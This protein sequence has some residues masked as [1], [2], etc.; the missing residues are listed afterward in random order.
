MS[1][2]V[3]VTRLFLRL[4][5]TKGRMIAMGALAVGM[6]LLALLTGNR[7]SPIEQT[8]S[9]FQLYALGG[10]VPIAA[11]VFGS[12]A[13]GDLVE[14]RTLVHLWLRPASRI[15][16]VGAAYLATV[17]VCIPITVIAPVIAMAV[18]KMSAS[19]IAASAVS[20]FTGTLAYAAVFLAVGLKLRRSLSWG[21]AYILIWEGVLA[22][23]GR[24]MARLA[25]RLSTRSIAFRSFEGADVNYA[26]S[27]GVGVVILLFVAV[28]GVALTW[29]W[30]NRADVA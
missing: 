19:A 21:L 23:I 18:G 10:L 25:L 17:L 1:T 3:S 14:D 5:A 22:N 7:E 12:S 20:T 24:G 29:R 9:L 16:L 26:V 11:L 15:V 6:I 30:L 13:F 8:W 2:F 28:A 27:S 4:L